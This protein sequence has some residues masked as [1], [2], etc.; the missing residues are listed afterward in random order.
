MK[1]L[2]RYLPP[3]AGDY[4]GV[5]S[6]LYELGGML[7]IHDASGCTGNYTGFDEPR[8][9]GSKAL[10]YCTALRK[11]DAILGN[12][13]VYIEKILRAAEEMKPKFIA[14]VGSPVPMVIGFD[15]HGVAKEIEKRSG[16]PTFGFATSGMQGSYKEGVVM[17]VSKFL[18]YYVPPV[19][20]LQE[21]RDRAMRKVNIVGATPLD[22]SEENLSA[23]KNLIR[24]N[25]Y[26]IVSVL[27]MGNSLE[28]MKEASTADINLAISQAGL[29]L[30]MEMYET[31]KIPYLAGLPIGEEGSKHYFTCLEKVWE[32]GE[33][34]AVSMVPVTGKQTVKGRNAVIIEDGV[35]ASSIKI[36]LLAQGYERVDVV[37]LFGKD[38]GMAMIEAEYPAG[39]AE[40]LQAVNRTDCELIVADPILLQQRQNQENVTL[41]ELPKYS[42]SSKLMHQR[43]WN[44][45][46]TAWNN[47]VNI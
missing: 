31:Y 37:S 41:L 32:E 18:E 13:E 42:I 34:L 38:K 7:C 20:A 30:A 43:R 47:H 26:E 16:I 10:I 2:Y 25:G 27:S 17:A 39:E 46:G 40:I 6:A 23:F 21:K 5:C 33:N 9:Y 22:L 35:L 14:L 1:R 4:S 19:Q 11:T 24:E 29:L 44:Y 28:E 36:E 45:I 3:F 15:F 8:S 12:E